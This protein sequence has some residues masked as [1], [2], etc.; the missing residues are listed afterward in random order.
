MTYS[1][2][3]YIYKSCTVCTSKYIDSILAFISGRTEFIHKATNSISYKYKLSSEHDKNI[4]K[5]YFTSRC[6]LK[7]SFDINF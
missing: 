4:D 2:I 1:L 7:L 6:I 5:P 3:I